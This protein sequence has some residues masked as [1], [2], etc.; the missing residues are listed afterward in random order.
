[1][2]RDYHAGPHGYPSDLTRARYR[3]EL[4]DLE[5][6]IGSEALEAIR[7]QYDSDYQGLC[8]A[9]E[10]RRNGDVPEVRP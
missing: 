9:A 10:A 8:D 6:E 2:V 5:A 1:M 3:S 7:E 4:R